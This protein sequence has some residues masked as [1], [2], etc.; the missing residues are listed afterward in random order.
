MKKK[1]KSEEFYH[2]I[3]HGPCV[4]ITSGNKEIRNI[5]PIAWLTPIN[6][7]PPLVGICVASSHY[8]SELID[9]YK[10]FVI[11]IPSVDLLD[12]VK[13]TGK[14]SGREKDKFKVVKVTPEDGIK[15]SI[16]HIK[17]CIGFIEVK[18]IETKEYDGV[19][20]YI[21]KV[22]HCEVED[23]LYNKYLD[24]KKAKTIHH[25]GGEKFFVSSGE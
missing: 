12:V 7:D 1:L 18:V 4:L 11:N 14:F 13:T 25:I 19:K 2:L 3:N 21:G 15:V 6:D 23:S 10:E 16:V 9:K 24:T 17:E 22:L 5:A 8:T 20:L